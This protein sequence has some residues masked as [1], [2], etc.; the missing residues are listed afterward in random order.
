MMRWG[1]TFSVTAVFVAAF[2]LSAWAQAG[3]PPKPAPGDRPEPGLQGQ[4][5]PSDS[6]GS[7]LAKPYSK[8]VRVVGHDPVAGRQGNIQ[9]AWV[10]HCA[11]ISSSGGAFPI[12]GAENVDESKI[13]VAVIDV[14]DASRPRLVKI[15]RDKGAIAALEALHAETAPDGR[16]VLVAGSYH[17]GGNTRGFSLS[18]LVE[19]EP[20]LDIY[21]V[22]DCANPRLTAEV[23]WP[24]NSHSLRL[25]PDARYIY[26]ARLG[27]TESGIQV[28]DITDLAKPRFIGKFGVTREDGTT[29]NFSPHEVSFSSDGRRVYA[30]VLRTKGGDLNVGVDVSKPSREAFGPEAGGIYIL[31]NSDFVDRRPNP[32]L[33]LISAIPGGG[34]HSVMP[35]RIDGVPYLAGGAE[36]NYCPGTWPRLVNIADEKKPFIVSE[37]KLEMNKQEHCY[38]PSPEQL[39]HPYLPRVGDA[40][41]HFNDV[42]SATDTRLGL[43]NFLWAGLRI[44]DLRDPAHPVEVGYFKPGDGC[45]G[46]VRYI[47]ESGHIWVSCTTSGFYVLQLSDE[48]RDRLGRQPGR[49]GN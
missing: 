39:A 29:F 15:L 10:D 18:K 34:W 8:G 7:I 32:K 31:D 45:G 17:G 30:A 19:D 20:W 24:E 23:K 21:D 37:F 22:S 46:H 11:Y 27:G 13:G 9:L 16:K 35:A 25:S 1:M 2:S 49:K 28:M 14:K 48:L 47:P 41:L 43:F 4:S 40:T 38:Q 6:P 26:G 3:S 36:I 33:R 12:L 44:A 5:M 42:D